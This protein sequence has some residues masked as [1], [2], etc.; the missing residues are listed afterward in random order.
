MTD[1]RRAINYDTALKRDQTGFP[2]WNYCPK[3]TGL[4]TEDD[5]HVDQTSQLM[6]IWQRSLIMIRAF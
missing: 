4:Y 1:E 2:L 5:M 6:S 3:W